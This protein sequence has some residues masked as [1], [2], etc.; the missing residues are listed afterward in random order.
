M[1]L[2]VV[3]DLI[4]EGDAVRYSI[5]KL[6]NEP[7]WTRQGEVSWE[8]FAKA[9]QFECIRASQGAEPE[10]VESDAEMNERIDRTTRY[11]IREV[12]GKDGA[13]LRTQLVTPLLGSIVVHGMPARIAHALVFQ[14]TDPRFGLGGDAPSPVDRQR[15]TLVTEVLLADSPQVLE[16]VF[17]ETNTIEYPWHPSA[18]IRSTSVGDI[19]VLLSP[20]NQACTAHQV[21]MMGYEEVEFA[22]A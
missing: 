14:E 2:Q 12:L 7:L 5:V 3:A 20:E 21:Q 8:E 17:R 11:A 1:D 19:V 15:Y 6:G 22:Q 10:A 16:D 18:Q 13:V 4:P 9:F